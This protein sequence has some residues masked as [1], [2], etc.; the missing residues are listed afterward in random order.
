MYIYV[1]NSSRSSSLS[2]VCDYGLDDRAI[3][4][5]ALAEAKVLRQKFVTRPVLVLKL[6]QPPVH[7]VQGV[8]APVQSVP[9]L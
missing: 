3:G 5:R 4:V 8:I 2:T 1:H 7:W 6:T 9:G